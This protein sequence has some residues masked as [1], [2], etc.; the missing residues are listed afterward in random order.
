MS[1]FL[2]MTSITTCS[3][4]AAFILGITQ[5]AEPLTGSALTVVTVA[6]GFEAVVVFVDEDVVTSSFLDVVVVSSFL[7]VVV[8]SSTVIVPFFEVAL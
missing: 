1:E 6:I 3:P 2:T 4:G 5:S 7:D 8:M